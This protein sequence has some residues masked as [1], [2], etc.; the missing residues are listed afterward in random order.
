MSRYR[1][2]I[3]M[4]ANPLNKEE[5]NYR[6]MLLET[7]A[8]R[9]YKTLGAERDKQYAL[10]V[11]MRVADE[12]MEEIRPQQRVSTNILASSNDGYLEDEGI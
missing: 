1:T 11:A 9:V 10:E 12:L 5:R 4:K 3:D 7:D 6:Q 2:D 8:E